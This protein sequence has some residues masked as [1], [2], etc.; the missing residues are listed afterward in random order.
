MC[1]YGEV[2]R[3]RRQQLF[4]E[5]EL[6]QIHALLALSSKRLED[7]AVEISRIERE[8]SALHQELHRG[9][10]QYPS[11]HQLNRSGGGREM[12]WLEGELD[13][14]QQH[15]SQLQARRQ[16]LSSQVGRLT[17]AEY[18]LDLDDSFGPFGNHAVLY[19]GPNESA[20]KRKPIS[21]W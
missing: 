21:T 12:V 18:F 2:E 8:I 3:G 19:N 16:E 6:A 11:H 15:V 14:V 17:S 5:R 13:R 7:A 10:H 1:D 9:R 20:A 4:L